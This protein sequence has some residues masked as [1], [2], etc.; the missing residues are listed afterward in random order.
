MTGWAAYAVMGGT[1]PKRERCW[2]RRTGGAAMPLYSFHCAKC[3]G[4]VERL[5]GFSET[6]VCPACGSKK[7]QRLISLTAPQRNSR[8]WMKSPRPQPPPNRHL[9]TF[10]RADPHPCPLSPAA[11]TP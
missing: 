2:D 7:L 3:D 6:P 4:D 5:I 1:D 10:I 9:T 11:P 8:A